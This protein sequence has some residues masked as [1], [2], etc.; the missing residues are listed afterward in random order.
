MKEIG[1]NVNVE[2]KGDVMT[3]TVDL[4]ADYG[5]SESKKSIIIATSEG[6]KSVP[7]GSGIKFGLNV[8]RPVA[9]S[10]PKKAPRVRKN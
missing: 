8:Y 2:V 1:S 5:P 10:K 7:D 4:S 9:S 6:P 3:I